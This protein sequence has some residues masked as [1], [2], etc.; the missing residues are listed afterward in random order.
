M[1][2]SEESHLLSTAGPHPHK[3]VLPAITVAELTST[4]VGLHC[5]GLPPTDSRMLAAIQPEALVLDSGTFTSVA[6]AASELRFPTVVVQQTG[7][8]LVVSC[9]C[10]IP[11]TSLCEHQ[12]LV[13]L[14]I[15]Q[16]KELRLFFDKPARHTF[17]R[18]QAR[19][20]GLEQADDLDAHFELIYSRPALVA[21][22]PR[23]PDLYAV[24]AATKQELITQ[25]LPVKRGPAADLPPS[26]QLLVLS[27][28]RF[29][30]HLTIY[31]A[32]AA[33][34]ATGKVKNPVNV[35]NP[36]DGIWQLQHP[37]EVKFYTA[38]SHFQRNYE[39]TRTSA[40]IS[41][42]RAVVQNP[43]GLPVY[44]HNTS[45]SDNI[46][47][48]SV[49]PVKLRH[50]KLDLRILVEQQGD[51][52]QVSG[53]LW[54]HDQP[55]DLKGLSI[56]YE[57]FVAVHGA[58]YLLD[59][60]DV[61]RVVE[62]FQKR[63]NTLLIH[64][65]KFGEFQRDVLANL[66]NRLHI[67]YG[68][69]RP[70]TSKQL[71]ESGFNESP[72]LL[73]YLSDAGGHVELLPVMR[74]GPTEVSILS[75]RQL[76][77][78]DELGRAFV[79]ARDA[80]AEN[81]YL[82]A[83]LR[84]YPD[85]QEQVNQESLYVPKSQFLQEE[86]FLDAFE[87][88]RSLGVTILGFNQLKSNT[89][90]PNKAH[91]T[92]R[93]TGENN[94]FDTVLRVRFGKQEA[95]MRNLHKAI[96]NKSR[97]VQL[98]DGTRGILP[99][100][101]VEKFASYFAAGEV[102]EDHIRTPSISFAT[103]EEL[104][105]PEAL[106][107][108]AQNQLAR[109]KAAVADFAG[110][111]PVNLPPDLRATLRDYQHQGLN[112]LNFLDTFNFGGCLADDMGLGKT[113]QVLAFILLQ[114]E[115]SPPGANLVV[116]P[117]S[118]VFNWLAE[119]EKFA[120]TL[121]VH[122]LHGADRGLHT[123]EFDGSDIVLTT[124][125]TVVSDIRWLKDYRFNYVFLDEAQAI[126]NPD[127]QR[128]RAACLLQARNRV[129]ITGTPVENN[130]YDLYGQLSFA[131][132]GL[133]GSRQHFQ[134]LYA[135]PID[136]F[137]DAKRARA[138]QR[139]I[140]PFVLRRTKTQVAAELPDKT[141]MVLYCEMGAEQRRVYEACKQEYRAKLM[142]LHEETPRKSSLHILQGLT[143]LRQICNAPALLREQEYYG[144][145]SAKLEAL[146]EEI[147]TKAPQHKILIFSQF[148]GMLNLIRREL[149]QR[150]IPYQYL[151][152][153][154]RNRAAAV[155]S[156][157]EDETV[158]VFLISLKAGG[159]GLNLTEADYVYLVDPWWNPAVENQAIDR[160]HRIGQNK[161]VVAVRLIC[162]D[163]IEEKI[164]K[165]QDGKRELAYELIKTDTALVKS[166]TKQELLEL[167][168]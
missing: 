56:Q 64:Q 116:V 81:S 130:T 159:T 154:T 53:K 54:L 25:L 65:S 60:L 168:S 58:L 152:G 100:E 30:G 61:W 43:A 19:D 51:Y 93:V 77:A 123:R 156:F 49:T 48:Q 153:Q 117:T 163:T 75:R 24:T 94:W 143:K 87:D 31:L 138:L 12:A 167:F 2:K 166:L 149:D 92:V 45:V 106:L 47:A 36:L 158:R 129:V 85:F 136:K 147:S 76:Y 4:I 111:K 68:Y 109:Y 105:E 84:H 41:A 165:L 107:P 112:W 88:W 145:A 103:L 50:T 95:S 125:N 164:M 73:L 102:V 96:R 17:L 67:T 66:E 157:Q 21:A 118:L 28:H 52:Y 42:L 18:T 29:Y 124:Y 16:R 59:D 121:R 63:N 39:D 14:S 122:V 80:A 150:D 132:P 101:W 119:I 98:D 27:K 72:E 71:A 90:N 13:L 5:V 133:L 32:E 131:C 44:A 142:G 9:A 11:K 82:A 148:V 91:V 135:A 155:T 114:R 83:L 3:Y 99:Q 86:W 20:Y 144:S 161:K 146:V 69:M 74:Y 15:V 10:T 34:T 46:T 97:Y 8:D 110:I 137:K 140:N 1:L 22:V 134:D 33:M 141:E 160:S 128:Y 89:Y 7:P 37:D 104:Y 79:L 35:I 70:A 120:P 151:T 57:Y 115:K 162:P 26:Q 6:H 126:K 62:F 78:T 23:R 55:F 40:A 139:K 113:L 127:S 108:N 38:I